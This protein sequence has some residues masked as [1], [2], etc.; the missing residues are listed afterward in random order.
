MIWVLMM[1]GTDWNTISTII[2]VGLAIIVGYLYP[3]LHLANKTIVLNNK[4][5]EEAKGLI[6]TIEKAIAD[7]R[8]TPDE[9]RQI[10]L[11]T[12][13]LFETKKSEEIGEVVNTVMSMI[14][15]EA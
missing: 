15:K 13:D 8:I 9:T 14:E 4:Q 5:K 6:D 7:G 3:K 2:S 10:I 12:K 1:T 11:K